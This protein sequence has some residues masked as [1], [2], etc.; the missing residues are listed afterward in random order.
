MIK[1]GWNIYANKVKELK[2]KDG[3]PFYSFSVTD[4]IAD[5]EDEKQY[6]NC[7]TYSPVVISD[8]AKLLIDSIDSISVNK[9]NGK[10]YYSL[11]LEV[12]KVS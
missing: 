3:T 9:Y 11:V 7:R 1:K 6:F 10:L 8:G 4:K 2:T 5:T 12:T